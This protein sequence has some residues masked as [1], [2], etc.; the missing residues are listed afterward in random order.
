MSNVP[1]LFAAALAIA[2]ILASL[3]IWSHRRL[4]VRVAA[5]VVTA[6][7]LPFAWASLVD[8]LSRPKPLSLEWA[9]EK[10]ADATVVASVM[11]EG[12]A[13]FIWLQLPDTP[14]PRAYALPWDEQRARE[15]HEANREAEASN[16]QVRMRESDG[17]PLDEREGLFYAAPQPPPPPKE[18]PPA[19]P[20]LF[21]ST[22]S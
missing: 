17:Q 6:L 9:S 13:I 12:E 2:G 8:L 10:M 5:L 18:V 14:E 3:S 21:E 15:L 19:N 16:S 7:Y 1:H 4:A 11:R 20:L 22:R